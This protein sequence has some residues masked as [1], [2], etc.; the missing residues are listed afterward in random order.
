MFNGG[1]LFFDPLGRPLRFVRTTS[2]FDPPWLSPSFTSRR[3][4]SPSTS[5]AAFSFFSPS[6]P[7]SNSRF[8]PLPPLSSDFG[9]K[10]PSL[11]PSVFGFKFSSLPPSAFGLHFLSSLTSTFGFKYSLLPPSACSILPSSTFVFKHSSLF[12][13]IM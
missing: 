13:G 6:Q 9:S 7:L 1:P 10:F 2:P 5:F 8:N 12:T 3:C 11:P 4:T